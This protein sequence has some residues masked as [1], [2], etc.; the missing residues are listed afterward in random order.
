MKI[1]ISILVLLLSSATVFA[2]ETDSLELRATY[3]PIDEVIG[4]VG[5]RAILLSDV[6]NMYMQAMFEGIPETGDLKCTLFEDLLLQKLLVNQAAID[7][8]EVTDKEVEMQL[9]QR[10]NMFLAQAGG[11]EKELERQFNKPI[12]Q[13]KKDLAEHM[14]QQL[15]TQRMRNFIS[16]DVKIT[17]SE[18]REYF[19]SLHKDSIPYIETELEIAEIVIKPEVTAEER[20]RV[21]NKLLDLKKQIE[22]SA[23]PAQRF[24]AFARVYSEDYGSQKQ[25]GELGFTPR[26]MLVPE[27][28]NAAFSLDVNEISG[29]V[30]TEYGFHI[31]QMIGRRGNLINV[32]HILMKPKESYEEIDRAKKILDSIATLVRK[33]EL[34]FAE[35]AKKYSDA[36]NGKNGGMIIN[37]MTNDTKFTNDILQQYDRSIY[38]AARSLE[39]AQ[40]SKPFESVNQDR[41]K[42]YKIIM[43]KSYTEGHVADMKE[44]YQRITNDA[45]ENKKEKV[46]RNWIIEKQK[47]TYIH[48]DPS[49]RNCAYEFPGWLKQ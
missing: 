33:N 9:N 23:N 37:P 21:K 30:E 5:N 16:E 27:F 2:Q 17:P 39:V 43:L 8:V 41:Q 19:K 26:D 35:A 3:R 22:E 6:E 10:I 31:I 28:S 25:G 38:R 36:D 20:A 13:I 45:L 29:V 7:S 14:K 46:F 49:F 4:V 47:S 12:K 42:V 11:D 44:D 40:I 1:Y 18:V 15:L 24:S 32:R 34:T 48:I